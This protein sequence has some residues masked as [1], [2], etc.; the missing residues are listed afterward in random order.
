MFKKIQKYLAVFT[1]IT[2]LVS[3]SKSGNNPLPK[4]TASFTWQS[5]SQ[6]APSIVTFSNLS[7]NAASYLWSFGDGST[8]V[9]INPKHTY[10]TGGTYLI[11][12]VAKNSEGNLDSTTKAISLLSPTELKVKVT[13]NLGTPISGATVTLF[14][15]KSDFDNFT[16]SV[17]TTTTNSN[18]FFYFSSNTS[19][20]TTLAYY[21]YISSGCKDNIHNATHFST[22]LIANKLNVYN[23]IILSSE[24][25]IK[26]YNNSTNPYEVYIDGVD[27][28]SLQ[29]GYNW[30][31]SS[32]A[33]ST[34]TVRVL[35]L[36][37]YLVY[38]TDETFNV[39]ITGCGNTQTVNFP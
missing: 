18:G 22:P 12:L 38:P 2:A 8:S 34:H 10:A 35:Q 20:I 32:Q 14:N 15:N 7:L 16:N 39:T 24:G 19:S 3:C 36:S 23:N 4:P 26:V 11:K 25:I 28:G 1:I 37:G 27:K 31:F 17:A 9:E 13:D 6:T 30:T 29:G 21:Y 33:V 5:S